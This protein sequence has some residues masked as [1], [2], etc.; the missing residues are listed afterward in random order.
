MSL[1]ENDTL[2]SDILRNRLCFVQLIEDNR[3]K[4]Q[5]IFDFKMIFSNLPPSPWI[6]LYLG[7]SWFSQIGNGLI[8]TVVG[9][10]QPFLVNIVY[11]LARPNFVGQTRHYTPS[12]TKIK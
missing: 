5:D 4:I 12:K 1:I 6:R 10:M 3:R 9:P 11:V 7:V 8:N 2:L